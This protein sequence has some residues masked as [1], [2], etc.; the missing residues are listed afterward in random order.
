MSA[1]ARLLDNLRIALPGALDGTIQQELFNT[2]DELCRTANAH[3]APF[4]IT[5]VV[6][7]SIYPVVVSG[8][9]T[10]TV[11]YAS[12]PGIVFDRDDGTATLASPPEDVRTIALELSLGPDT[13]ELPADWLPDTVWERQYQALL[14]GVLGRM[15]G[16]IA[17]PYSDRITGAYHARRFRNLMAMARHDANT[18]GAPGAQRWRYPRHGR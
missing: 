18:G 7:Q 8:F 9:V 1:Y 15:M 16:Q 4:A 12:D 3:R 11:M 10:L 6:G 13:L 5:T 17:K 14:H 2:V